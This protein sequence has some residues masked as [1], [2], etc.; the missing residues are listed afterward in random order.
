VGMHRF[1]LFNGG[2]TALRSAWTEASD[3]SQASETLPMR[4]STIKNGAGLDFAS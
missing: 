3:P 1:P 2:C 4:L